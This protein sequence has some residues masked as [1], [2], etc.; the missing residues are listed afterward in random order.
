MDREWLQAA[1]QLDGPLIHEASE[2][3][4][5]RLFWPREA[6][7]VGHEPVDLGLGDYPSAEGLK[8]E[9]AEGHDRCNKTVT[10][11]R[12]WTSSVAG[13]GLSRQEKSIGTAGFVRFEPL[14]HVS[15]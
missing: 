15:S 8:K 5:C 7:V 1:P 14:L 9:L 10:F 4:E 3:L 6:I 11:W 12:R 13:R 2:P